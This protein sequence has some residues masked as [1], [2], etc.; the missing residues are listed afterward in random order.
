MANEEELCYCED[1]HLDKD[2]FVEAELSC[3]D[4]GKLLCPNH[5]Y[6]YI[7]VQCEECLSKGNDVDG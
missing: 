6:L 5:A 2:D 3:D 4:C 7:G 1:C